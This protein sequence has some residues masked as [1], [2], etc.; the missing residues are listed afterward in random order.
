MLHAKM[1]RLRR[2]KFGLKDKAIQE[3]REEIPSEKRSKG[4]MVT[5]KRSDVTR[6][7]ERRPVAK[8]SGSIREHRRLSAE[9]TY[10]NRHVTTASLPEQCIPRKEPR[11]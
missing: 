7:R 2:R 6:E 8:I 10:L 1:K 5:R 9:N 3:E 4:M 11:G